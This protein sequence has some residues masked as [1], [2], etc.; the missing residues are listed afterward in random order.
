MLRWEST[1]LQSTRQSTVYRSPLVDGGLAT[2]LRSGVKLVTKG[3]DL[4][5]AGRIR[6]PGPGV[7]DLCPETQ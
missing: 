4:V 2:P 6:A 5:E 1:S 7:L 3:L